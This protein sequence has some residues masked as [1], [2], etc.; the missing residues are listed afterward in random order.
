MITFA[1]VVQ[2][3]KADSPIEITLLGI[4]IDANDVH[5]SNADCLIDVTLFPIVTLIKSFWLRNGEYFELYC[6]S[7]PQYT[8]FNGLSS[9]RTLSPS[10]FNN[11]LPSIILIFAN[12]VQPLKALTSIKK[13]LLGI[14]IDVSEVQPSKAFFQ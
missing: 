5:P 12:E 7:L 4:S 6:R 8:S 2:P 9:N 11:R 3:L 14:L 13:T 1:N 10:I